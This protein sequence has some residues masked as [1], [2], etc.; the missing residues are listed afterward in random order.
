ML[1]CQLDQNRSRRADQPTLTTPLSELSVH[2]FSTDRE[3]AQSVAAAWLEEVA[4]QSR[5]RPYCVALSGGRITLKF[6]EA[7]ITESR[8][9]RV[10]LTNVEF[11]WADER[12]VP[13]TDVESSFGAAEKGFFQPLAIPTERIHRI[14]G[15][16]TPEFAAQQAEAEICR[17]AP[18]D[19]EGQPV[20]DLILLGMG[21]DG[22]VASL[23]PAEPESLITNPSVYRVIRNSPKPPP[24]RVTL[25]YP[26]IAAARNIWVLISGAGKVSALR[27]S[28]AKDGK[29]PLARVLRS[30]SSCRVFTDIQLG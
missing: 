28:L 21:E 11:F 23:F 24:V 19:A 1:H 7:A 10:L 30:H 3:L 4:R 26:A 16:E 27:E 9:R 22:H 13:P 15:E 5:N 20:L 12:C 18:L 8:M 25:G 17:I 29:T 2:R 14:R 6:F